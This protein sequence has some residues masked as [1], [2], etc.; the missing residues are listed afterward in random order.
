[1]KPPAVTGSLEYVADLEAVLDHFF[2]G[3]ADASGRP[4]PRRQCLL[5]STPGL[6]PERVKRL[7]SLDGFGIPSTPPSNGGGAVCR[8]AG[9][10]QD[11]R[12]AVVLR[13]AGTR[14]RPAAKEQYPPHPRTCLC[15]SPRT[16]LSRRM[17]AAGT[18]AP[19]GAQAAVPDRLPARRSDQHL[20][21]GY[22]TNALAR[23][24]R[25]RMPR[26]G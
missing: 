11:G 23:R 24:Q 10:H 3:R 7:V 12:H 4:Q 22:G 25:I 5:V 15:G 19:T 21:A 1:M 6:R 20:A 13:N 8:M 14:R 2:A 9:R 17:T 16:G 26:N 18:C